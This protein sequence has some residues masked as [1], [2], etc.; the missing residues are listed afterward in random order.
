MGP[1]PSSAI[2]PA[3][4]ALRVR[5]LS[6]ATA[7]HFNS[8][9]CMVSTLATTDPSAEV[10]V[11]ALDESV[12]SRDAA[13]RAA[14]PRLR[15]QPVNWSAL[16]AFARVRPALRAKRDESLRAGHYAWKPLLISREAASREAPRRDATVWLDA[17]HRLRGRGVVG[18]L[19]RRARA[20]G[21]VFSTRSAGTAAQWTHE[22]MI[23]RMY[24][25]SAAAAAPSRAV[26]GRTRPARLAAWPN[27][28]A[29]TLA[30]VHGSSAARELLEA[31]SA[32]ARDL[33]CIAP[34]GSSRANHRQDQ[35][36]LTLL[37]QARSGL[38]WA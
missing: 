5:V 28:D 10:L 17:E 9:R 19:V 37:L 15:V 21:G 1:A 13:L 22:G 20:A 2:P 33:S 7:D 26:L 16:P 35:A 23:G 27:C 25:R 3:A 14:N 8:L 24:N 4:S 30:L 29:S 31:W 11:F 6:A 34:E 36:A 32:C 18:E 12:A 38:L